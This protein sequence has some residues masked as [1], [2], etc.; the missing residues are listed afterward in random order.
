MICP[1][2]ALNANPQG[3]GE[4]SPAFMPR[5]IP[6]ALPAE[7]KREHGLGSPGILR[8]LPPFGH[9]INIPLG[10]AMYPD[11]SIPLRMYAT[12]QYCLP[13]P[14]LGLNR[15]SPHSSLLYFHEPEQNMPVPLS[16]L[17]LQ[18]YPYL[19]GTR[20]KNILMRSS[21]SNR[22]FA[23]S[24][25][26]DLSLRQSSDHKAVVTSA[27]SVQ[28]NV[29]LPRDRFVQATQIH[30]PFMTTSPRRPSALD[31]PRDT[32]P[33]QGM[34]ASQ[35]P[36]PS[37]PTSAQ[38]GQASVEM[39]DLQASK[40]SGAVS[41][42]TLSYPLTRQ[43]GKIRYECNICGKIFGQLS[44]LKVFPSESI[45]PPPYHIIVSYAS[46]NETL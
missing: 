46:W 8:G 32:S 30:A 3:L 45:S 22:S 41:Y 28:T 21:E 13:C 26:S 5:V 12:S 9:G 36:L 4:D 40:H 17:Q 44:N 31:Q 18:P 37:K 42:R 27:D 11:C 14:P 43:N 33:L 7:L 19:L 16:L 39:T 38:L 23:S 29:G 1:K 25:L 24:Y 10:P 34:A 35:G 2:P 20:Q 6:N 15:V